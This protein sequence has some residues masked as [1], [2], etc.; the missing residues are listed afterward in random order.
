V[1]HRGDSGDQKWTVNPFDGVTKPVVLRL[2][3]TNI[4]LSSN[5]PT[6]A[7]NMG[8]NQIILG[9]PGIGQGGFIP[10][11]TVFTPVRG[12]TPP[13]VFRIDP[14]NSGR[15]AISVAGSYLRDI[16]VD[17]LNVPTGKV[18]FE[19]N[20]VRYETFERLH[21]IHNMGTAFKLGAS[22]DGGFCELLMIR[23]IWTEIPYPNIPPPEFRPLIEIDAAQTISWSDSRLI[24]PLP[25]EP[26]P[27]SIGIL[28]QGNSSQNRFTNVTIAGPSVHIKI[29]NG[30]GGT[31]RECRFLNMSHERYNIGYDIG[32]TSAQR[33]DFNVIDNPIFVTPMG[34]SP[35]DILLNDYAEWSTVI[36]PNFTGGK[37]K[38]VVLNPMAV[39]NQVWSNSADTGVVDKSSGTNL[40]FGRLNAGRSLW[41]PMATVGSRG[42]GELGA[43]P[44]GS[45]VYCPN[46]AKTTPC[47]A[48]GRGALAKHMGG[49]W[50]CN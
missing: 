2:G 48:G 34:Q 19:L 16:T 7:I 8:D 33:A 22:A 49:V 38:V 24:G 3:E 45:I 14:V 4:A 30:P 47:S 29:Q 44:D 6:A 36:A 5:S 1:D 17:M 39:D 26:N 28:I 31:P 9:T 25:A 27:N 18:V 11:G 15:R 12:F 35:V 21:V 40:I 42:F 41:T 23:D 10:S 32:G 43:A 46:C 50:D 20:S 37:A 13:S